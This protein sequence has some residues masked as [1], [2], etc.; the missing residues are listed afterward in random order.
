M[1][2]VCEQCGVTFTA[3]T[4]ARRFCSRRCAGLWQHRDRPRRVHTWA[5]RPDVGAEHRKLRRQLLPAA[6]GKPCPLGCGRIMDRTAELDHAIPRAAGGPTTRDNC[7]IICKPCNRRRGSQLGA[8]RAR[9]ARH[10]KTRGTATTT[11]PTGTPWHSR[12]W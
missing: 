10:N 12:Q 4:T 9:A 5:K 2:H 8:R 6:L 11:T 1:T 3:T 7:R